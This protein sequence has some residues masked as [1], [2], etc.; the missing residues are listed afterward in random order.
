M[1]NM[2]ILQV[3]NQIDTCSSSLKRI[4]DWQF[5]EF[6]SQL[7]LPFK[8]FLPLILHQTTSMRYNTDVNF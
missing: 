2:I 4:Q 7:Y 5:N 8:S 6:Y 3:V 1:M